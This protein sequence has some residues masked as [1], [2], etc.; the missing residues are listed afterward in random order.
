M[1]IRMA[2]LPEGTRVRIRQGELPLDAGLAGRT[3]VIIA[4]S[5]YGDERLGVQL[6]DE[7]S[8]CVFAPC[9]LEVIDAVPLPPERESAKA[10]RAL[11]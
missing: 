4:A 2:R 6:D 1:A 5:D 9:E 11:P 3:G 8:V 7:S 10:R